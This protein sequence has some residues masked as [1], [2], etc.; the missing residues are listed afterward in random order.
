MVG[1]AQ[2][3]HG[4]RCKL[5]GG[6]SN[7]VPPISVIASIATLQSL[8]ADAPLSLLR[9]PKKDSFKT[10]VTPFSRSMWRVVRSSSLAKGDTSKTRPSP[11]LHKVSTRSNKVSPRTS[12]TGLVCYKFL[13]LCHP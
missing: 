5:H 11:H 8:N 1:K 3:S 10:T 4:A 13:S 6:C 9:H 2:K 12:R 7:G